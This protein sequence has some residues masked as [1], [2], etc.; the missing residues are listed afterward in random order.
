[1][2]DDTI[3]AI[4]TPLGQGGLAIIRV[5]GE[6]AVTVGDAVFRPPNNI[7]VFSSLIG[8][9]AQLFVMTFLLLSLALLGRCTT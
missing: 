6:N 4:A 5:S 8:M 9:G 1:M 3:A 2:L 7:M